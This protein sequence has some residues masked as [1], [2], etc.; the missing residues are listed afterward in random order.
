MDGSTSNELQTISK[1]GSTVTLSDGGGSFTDADTDTHL[2][3]TQVDNYVSNNGYLTTEVDGSTTN[4]LQ[5]I[6][7]SGSTVTLS[8][9]GGSFT[10]NDT[11]YTAGTGITIT[12]TTIINTGDTDASDDFSGDYGD[13]SNKPITFYEVGSTNAPNDINDNIFHTGKIAIGTNTTE[14]YTKLTVENSGSGTQYQ[15]G[16]KSTLNG[17]G[18]GKHYATY[19]YLSGAGTGSQFGTFSNISNSGNSTHY[20]TYNELSG[21]GSGYHYATY[22]TLSG[23]GTGFQYGTRTL[24]SN[25][26]NGDHYATYNTLSGTGIGYQYGTNTYITNSGNGH[27]Y[28]TYNELSGSGSGY[29]SATY[30][31]LSGSGNGTHCGI[32]NYLTSTGSG[33]HY[34]IFNTLSG[35]GT[36]KQYG[37]ITDITNSGNN[38]HYGT[39]NHLSGSGTGNKYGSYNSISS[40]AGGTH[41]AVYGKALKAGSYAGYFV[42]NTRVEGNIDITKA[43]GNTLATVSTESGDADLYIKSTG[44]NLPSLAFYTDNAYRT[45]IGYNINH[46]ALFIYHGQN[47]FFKDGNILPTG[48]KSRDLGASGNAWD[49][50]YADNFVNEG[51]AAFTD[52]SVTAELIL[53]KPIAKKD[54][55]FDAKT[56][57]GLYEL[58]PD[59]LPD[60]LRA[61]K[62]LLIDEIA[63]YNYKANYE[64]Q[65]Q[66]N[67]LKKLVEKQQELIEKLSKKLEELE[68]K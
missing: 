40:T 2:T 10:D 21:S 13:L 68:S 62:G 33:N 8:D 30:N 16:I 45:S 27:H 3:E 43:S 37:I 15:Y 57:K 20:G 59:S 66:L 4:E 42:G 41:Y 50:V 54:G 55:D 11:T 65:V 34:A 36:G 39:K 7:K 31:K 67:E 26:G 1:I 19:N 58:N 64:Q 18:S 6:S 52:R 28:G 14:S 25:S 5:T 51:A 23:A 32:D 60:A 9:G 29:H 17:T 47:V 49:D 53:H 44:T 22:N 61:E 48:H 12:G 38:T 63:T 35:A 24:I 46:D 56:S